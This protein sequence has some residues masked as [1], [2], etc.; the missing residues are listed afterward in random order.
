MSGGGGILSVYDKKEWQ[1]ERAS[2]RTDE[3]RLY[4]NAPIECQRGGGV[5]EFETELCQQVAEAYRALQDAQAS[6]E[7][8][9]IRAYSQRM[10]YL[11][12]IAE[13]HGVDLA[14]LEL[15]AHAK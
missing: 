7:L 9:A 1:R 11:V 14:E 2:E 13:E 12:G 10:G 15:S 6:D 4:A 5:S 3:H 8:G